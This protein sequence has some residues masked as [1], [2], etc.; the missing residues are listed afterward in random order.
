MDGEVIF[1]K[2]SDW[3]WAVDS[4]A[5]KDRLA[6]ISDVIFFVRVSGPLAEVSDGGA[7]GITPT[8]SLRP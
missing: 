6:D 1:S 5:A 4:G 3:V 7:S 2:G 8:I